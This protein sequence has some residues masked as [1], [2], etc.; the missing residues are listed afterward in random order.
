MPR[1]P[2]TQIL[3]RQCAGYIKT[4]QRNNNTRCAA[5]GHV[6]WVPASQEWEGPIPDQLRAA[7]NRTPVLLTCKHCQHE[8]LSRAKS[9]G[10]V[11]C[12][13]CL[14]ARRVP[15]S[16]RAASD[17][18]WQRSVALAERNGVRPETPPPS[19]GRYGEAE[20]A[21]AASMGRTPRRRRAP[22]FGPGEGFLG[23]DGGLY[24]VDPAAP[25]PRRRRVRCDQC[26]R[27]H[28]RE[29]SDCSPPRLT[30]EQKTAMR[31]EEREAAR[32]DAE[33]F[34]ATMSAIRQAAQMF[35]QRRGVPIPEV[36]AYEPDDNYTEESDYTPAPYVP[37]SQVGRTEYLPD[38][39]G[40]RGVPVTYI[41]IRK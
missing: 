26:G 20:R 17:P 9:G 10:T 34:S 22:A 37:V 18:D 1:A 24:D 14:K 4:R 12:P 28:R 5:C 40:G 29:R 15:S 11:R 13:D 38:T 32:R 41:D 6:Q 7:V 30:A 39:A 2:L 36:P 21:A 23:A 35:A 8:W 33:Q 27:L 25:I 3:C 19:D 31:A 16:A